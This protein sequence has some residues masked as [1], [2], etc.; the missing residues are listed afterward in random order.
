MTKSLNATLYLLVFIVLIFQTKSQALRGTKADKE[1]LKYLV[2]LQ[3]SYRYDEKHFIKN[4]IM[5]F[6]SKNPTFIGGGTII[7]M[8]WILTAN[9]V[10]A[11]YN[12]TGT[13]YF[14]DVVQVTA[15]TKDVNDADAQ[16]RSKKQC[17][18]PQMVQ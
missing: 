9:H 17:L 2:H 6:R 3:V 1:S 11:D 10:V 16:K 7:N 18:F 8:N 14:R 13:E 15:G 4:W 12:E 5:K